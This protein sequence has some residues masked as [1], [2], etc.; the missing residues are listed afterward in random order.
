MA[1]LSSAKPRL[2]RDTEE[3]GTK[4]ASTIHDTD[5]N[6]RTPNGFGFYST[7]VRRS[8]LAYT[9]ALH[10]AWCRSNAV[11]PDEIATWSARNGKIR[12]CKKR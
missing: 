12:T 1:K 8:E 10:P 2:V 3:E 11:L 5:Y 7:R 9:Y 4:D 6:R